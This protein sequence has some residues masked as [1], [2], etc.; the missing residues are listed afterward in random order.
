[1]RDKLIKAGISKQDFNQKKTKRKAL[2][3]LLSVT[4]ASFSCGPAW[5]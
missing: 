2:T 3:T 4:N 5:A 1:M